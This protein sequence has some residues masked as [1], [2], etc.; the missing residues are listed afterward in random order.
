MPELDGFEVIRT[1]RAREQVRGER[2]PVIALTARARPADRER[3]LAEGMDDVLTKPIN[4]AALSAALE[5]VA[6]QS[7]R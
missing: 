6:A 3:C 4:G 2:L 1:L 5:R 7:P